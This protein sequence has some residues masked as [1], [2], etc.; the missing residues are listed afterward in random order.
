LLC[1]KDF[2][3]HADWLLFTDRSIDLFDHFNSIRSTGPCSFSEQR[4][5][6][7]FGGVPHG[8]LTSWFTLQLCQ[9]VDRTC[10]VDMYKLSTS[11]HPS[12]QNISGAIISPARLPVYAAIVQRQ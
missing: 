4:L 11:R 1:S 10:Q 7:W 3:R 12:H 9:D 5:S 2:S 8:C 6:P